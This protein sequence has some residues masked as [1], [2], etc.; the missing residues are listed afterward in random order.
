[1][2]RTY[3]VLGLLMSGTSRAGAGPPSAAPGPVTG[4]SSADADKAAE[5]SRTYEVR[6]RDG[7]YRLRFAGQ[8]GRLELHHHGAEH[9]VRDISATAFGRA[10]LQSQARGEFAVTCA[11]PGGVSVA[12]AGVEEQ[13]TGPPRALRLSATFNADGMPVTDD[14][15][16]PAETL[17]YV[18]R[19]L[20]Q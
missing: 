19:M 17:D 2:L 11:L 8:A 12:F 5:N 4:A 18:N 10:M 15:L 16:L 14:G 7:V 20:L 1:M 3:L 6:C 9:R 13:R